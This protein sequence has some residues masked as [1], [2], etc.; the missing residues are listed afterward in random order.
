MSAITCAFGRMDTERGVRGGWGGGGDATEKPEA[1]VMQISSKRDKQIWETPGKKLDDLN[2]PRT[3]PLG[4]DN[5]RASF[6]IT[7]LYAIL[8]F[9]WLRW[10]CIGKE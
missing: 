5:G 9:D 3:P 1:R 2:S 4:A 8:L 7:E 6:L 10:R